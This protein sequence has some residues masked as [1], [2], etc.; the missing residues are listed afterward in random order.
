MNPKLT[1]YA[2]YGLYFAGLAAL[3][4]IGLYF[5]KRSFDLPVQIAI[6]CIV[7]GLALH[8]I[9][10]PQGFRERLTG[11]QARHG[12]NALLIIL[13]FLGILIVVNLLA[14]QYSR[15]WDLTEDKTNT[16]AV[17]SVEALKSLKA[18]VRA[19][20][21]FSSR[22]PKD[23]AVSLLTKIKTASDGKF[24]FQFIDP[25]ANPAAARA[26]NV[27]RD[28]TLVLVQGDR[29][30][31]LSM[32]TESEVLNG[33]VR[34]DNPGSRAVYFLTGHGEGSLDAGADR[35]YQT[36]KNDLTAKNYT[37]N[38]LNLLAERKIPE[39]ALAIIIAGPT[40]PLSPEE[41]DLLKAYLSGK[42]AVVYLSEPPTITGTADL[43]N[44]FEDYLLSDWG[45]NLVNDLVIDLNYDPAV[46]A[47]AGSYGAHDI[48]NKMQGETVV[49]PITR[50]MELAASAQT[51][52]LATELVRTSAQSW[53]E[54][55]QE[56][57][58]SN[59][60][61]YDQDVDVPGPVLIAVAAEN[62][63]T[64]TRLVVTGDSEFAD[65]NYISQYGNSLFI[66][67]AIAWAAGQDNLINLT[68]NQ[69]TQRILVMRDRTMMNL[70]FLGS[71]VL[72]PALVTIAG[73]STWISRRRRG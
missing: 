69:P 51:G 37:V 23:Q 46:I 54:T 24:D 8:V 1:K 40:K 42:G 58:Q 65:D 14:N 35:T 72:L 55:N 9:L 71:V 31:Q 41:V 3:A 12:T 13:S 56:E 48:T 27:T 64:G 26:A 39:D 66:S 34:L 32:A 45:I 49:M 57:L 47:I 70:V 61:K 50:S 19:D 22:Y 6:A 62:Q 29:S 21:Y 63:Q 44:P 53:G 30:E 60:V 4:A 28:G 38:S 43:P 10:D 7:L 59:R 18:P 33:L 20:A 17:E 5:F 52:A 11:R 73:V 36:L 68:T 15:S 25:E 67:N 2:P 16:L